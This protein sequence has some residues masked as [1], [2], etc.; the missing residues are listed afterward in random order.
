MVRAYL[1][2]SVDIWHLV[3]GIVSM[4]LLISAIPARHGQCILCKDQRTRPGGYD[5][6]NDWYVGKE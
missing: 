4:V 2:L 1:G 3:E 6:G 5:T